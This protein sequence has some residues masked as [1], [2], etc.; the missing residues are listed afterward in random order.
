MECNKRQVVR[1]FHLNF[2][3]VTG[4]HKVLQV[5]KQSDEVYDLPT[6]PPGFSQG[7]RSDR[8]RKVS[9]VPFNPRHELWVSR[10]SEIGQYEKLV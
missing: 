4:K 2:L 9:K 5:L 8:G 1:W 10:N 3:P 7:E 6:K